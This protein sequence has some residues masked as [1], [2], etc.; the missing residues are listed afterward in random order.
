MRKS[1]KQLFVVVI[2]IFYNNKFYAEK[3]GSSCGPTT[4]LQI[5]SQGAN[6]ARELVGWQ[7]DINKPCMTKNYGAA[8][9]AFEYQQTSNSQGLAQ[10]LFGSSTLSFAGSLVPNRNPNDF[11]AENF[12]LARDFKGSV[13]FAPFI[14]NI[15]FDLGLYFGLDEY[16]QNF[17]VR[18]HMPFAQTT[19]ELQSRNCNSECEGSIA[20]SPFFYTTLYAPGFASTT[21]FT[22]IFSIK[23]ALSGIQTYG[24]MTAQWKKG[25]FNF[26]P[27][28]LGGLADL[29]IIFGYNCIN[30]PKAR[31]GLYLQMVLPTGTRPDG[32]YIFEPI[33]GNGHHFEL[34]GGLSAQGL[35]WETECSALGIF[36]EGNITHMFFDRQC[37]V[38]DFV[39]NDINPFGGPFSRYLLLKEFTSF[40]YRGNLVPAVNINNRP[41]DVEIKVKA[42]FSLKLAYQ[43]CGFNIDIGYNIY[44]NSP[45]SICLASN[46]PCDVVCPV[47]EFDTRVSS[48]YGL[49]GT[50]DV[51]SPTYLIAESG[52]EYYILPDGTTNPVLN[53]YTQ[54]AGCNDSNF[55]DVGGTFVVTYTNPNNLTQSD[56]NIYHAGTPKCTNAVNPVV[57]GDCYVSLS[58]SGTQVK[59]NR[60]NITDLTIANKYCVVPYN[61]PVSPSSLIDLSC[62]LDV[63]SA[64]SPGMLT[65]KIFGHVSYSWDDKC[66]WF[67]HVGFGVEAEFTTRRPAQCLIDYSAWGFWIKGGL[68][69]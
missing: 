44:G 56:S 53:P 67:P 45:E 40:Y 19:Y 28:V 47:L 59:D 14:R 27:S 29:D 48:Q 22:P 37:R 31:L 33:L 10:A 23:D 51:W 54:P 36:V 9:F 7:W 25:R 24:D 41:C 17:Y 64:A 61:V 12:G 16:L 18:V 43:K 30:N 46:M 15:I 63:D 69:F 2:L 34:G 38:F 3:C 57:P 52:A 4:Y 21:G 66:G 65:Q 58:T 6:T 50:E 39:K 32:E 11:L 26:Q 68:S 42:D 49:K 55:P 60:V 8:Y 1:Y 20:T 35:F 13:T 5:R 62:S